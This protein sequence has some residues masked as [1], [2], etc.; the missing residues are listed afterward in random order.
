MEGS[1]AKKKAYGE[2]GSTLLTGAK[3]G[4]ALL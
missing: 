4:L 3:S 1:L 2:A